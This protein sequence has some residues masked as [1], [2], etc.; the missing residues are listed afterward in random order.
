MTKKI[1]IGLVAVLLGV[2]VYYQE[3]I[4]SREKPDRE[5]SAGMTVRPSGDLNPP[6]GNSSSDKDSALLCLL[7]SWFR[8]RG[9]GERDP[10]HGANVSSGLASSNSLS[11]LHFVSHSQ[12]EGEGEVVVI[13]GDSPDAATRQKFMVR[14]ASGAM[15]LIDHDI[16]KA[17]RVQKLELGDEIAFC[18]EYSYDIDGNVVRWTHKDPSGRH[19]AGW[20]K[21]DG[22]TYQ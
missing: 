14:L 9:T 22:R 5:V 3:S 18:G 12:V 20:L 13:L 10:F 21:H 7:R 1:M 4:R 15:L 8:D 16:E 6:S 17:P 19:P 2:G 11:C